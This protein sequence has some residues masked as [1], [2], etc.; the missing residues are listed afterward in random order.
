MVSVAVGG[1]TGIARDHID[2]SFVRAGANT[3][4]EI[5]AAFGWPAHARIPDHRGD[6]AGHIAIVSMQQHG[7]LVDVAMSPENEV[8]A[9][10]FQDGQSVLS[11]FNVGN[12]RVGVMGALRIWRMM[13]E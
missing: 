4:L 6:E 7:A 3:R 2:R 12:L 8:D 1:P 11:H 5:R 13:E 9:I 10:G